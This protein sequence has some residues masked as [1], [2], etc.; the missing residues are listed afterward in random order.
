M[1]AIRVFIAIELPGSIQQQLGLIIHQLQERVPRAVR[2]VPAQNIH[3]TLKFLGNVSPANLAI[4]IQAVRAEAAR[5]PAMQLCVGG[6]G[7]FPNTNRPRVIWAGVEAPT[8]LVNL[9]HGLDRETARLGYAGEERS[10]SAHLTLGRVS[11][12][13]NTM[14][15]HQVADALA[16]THLD[17]LGMVVVKQLVLFRSDLRPGGAVYAPLLKA[18]LGG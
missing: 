10:F 6:L 13:A 12:H 1:D 11:Q 3:L 8:E 5:H 9:Q 15:V 2:W 7:A 14:E 18:P 4:L 17:D 16:L